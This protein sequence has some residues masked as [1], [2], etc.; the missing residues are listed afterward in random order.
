MPGPGDD[1]L[2]KYFDASGKSWNIMEDDDKAVTQV[3][4]FLK[5][6][7]VRVFNDY[8]VL[9]KFEQESGKRL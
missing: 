3:A 2:L 6:S 8:S 4:E 7:G 9:L 1:V 5:R